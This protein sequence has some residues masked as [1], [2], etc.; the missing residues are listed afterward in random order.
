LRAGDILK[1]IVGIVAVL[2][3]VIVGLLYFPV[4][5]PHVELGAEQVCQIAG[6]PITNTLIASWITIVVLLAIF[7]LGTRRMKMMPT[8]LQNVVEWIY[9]SLY[10]FAEEAAGKENTPKFFP[11]FATIFLYVIGAAFIS[12]IPGFDTIGDGAREHFTGAFAGSYTGWVVHEPLLR[13]ASSDIN[14][15]LALALIAFASWTY[16][17]IRMIGVRKYSRQFIKLENLGEGFKLMSRGD[18]KSAPMA[19][20]MGGVDIFV[21]F[22]EFLSRCIQIVSLTF[23]LFGNMLAGAILLLIILYLIPW[24]GGVPFYGLEALFGFVQALI[25][26]GLTLVFSVIATTAEHE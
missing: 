6:F 12:L 15:P 22:L 13:K 10:N 1:A 25:F 4:P 23:R 20:F 17:A 24:I 9:E 21:G 7:I 14:F 16:W 3:A 19:F 18:F 8:G 26:A 11:L 5:K 2:G